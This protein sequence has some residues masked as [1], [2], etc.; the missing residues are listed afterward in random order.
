MNIL[1]DNSTTDPGSSTGIIT[2]HGFVY[3]Y[4]LLKRHNIDQ[5]F[6]SLTTHLS[7]HG[8]YVHSRHTIDEYN[9]E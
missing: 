9:D 7:F 6:K 8:I 4:I 5:Y 2:L 3:K 1:I